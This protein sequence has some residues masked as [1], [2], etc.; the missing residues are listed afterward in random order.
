VALAAVAILGALLVEAP[1]Q[2]SRSAAEFLAGRIEERQA[3]ARD[4]TARFVQTYT[5]TIG[6]KLVE[7]GRVQV[8]RPGRMRWEYE[9]PERKTFVSDGRRFFFYVPRDKQVVVRDQDPSRSLPALLLS[10]Q[11]RL[12]DQFTASLE[13]GTPGRTRLRLVPRSPDPEIATVLLDADEQHRIRAIEVEDAQGTKSRFEFD[14]IREN[15][16][17]SEKVFHF[18]PPRGVEVIAG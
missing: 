15:V 7:R 16:G 5:S 10:G 13:T 9:E 14:E 8:K 2:P 4:M 18:E 17:L 6:R 11:G 12:L 3:A 1:A